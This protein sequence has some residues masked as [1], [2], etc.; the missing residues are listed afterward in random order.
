[1]TDLPEGRGQRVPGVDGSG[2][3]A[4]L[5]IDRRASRL[6]A[7]AD[8]WADAEYDAGEALR[9]WQTA[10]ADGLYDAYAVYGAALEREQR[11]AAMLA[12]AAEAQR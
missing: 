3:A 1:M 6:E 12:A 5:G 8:A 4:L 2:L 10:P 7:F 11:A 9:A